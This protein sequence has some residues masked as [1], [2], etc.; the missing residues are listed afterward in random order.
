MTII[1]KVGRKL[2]LL[3]GAIGT[4]SCLAGVAAIFLTHQH[5]ELLVWLLVVYI[6]FFAFSQ[7]AV[8][9][10]YIGEVFPNRVRAQGQ[11]LG[12]F[13]HWFM[14]GV[15]SLGFPPLA[16]KSGGYPFI[17]FSIMTVVQ[18]FVVLKV[19]PETKGVSLEEM[20]RKLGIA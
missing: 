18:F 9:W 14:A 6:A 11:S 12:S 3:I 13:S 17:F 8:I 4:A 2:L 7:G 5:K 19:Y 1:D 15:I 16:A 10:V 20:Q